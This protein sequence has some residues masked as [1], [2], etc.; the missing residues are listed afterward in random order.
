MAEGG[1]PFAVTKSETINGLNMK[2]GENT[3]GTSELE[4]NQ[5]SAIDSNHNPTL[6][7]DSLYQIARTE[8]NKNRKIIIR[9][10]PPVTYEV[11]KNRACLMQ[12]QHRLAFKMS[13]GERKNEGKSLAKKSC[14]FNLGIRN[15]ILWNIAHII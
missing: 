13:L 11:G 3:Q 5:Y 14:A 12:K 6:Q 2:N 1:L 15:E 9:N 8:F 7:T 4:C 10:V